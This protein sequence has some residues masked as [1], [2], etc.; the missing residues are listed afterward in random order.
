MYDIIN[1][2]LPLPSQWCQPTA[3]ALPVHLITSESVLHT[4]VKSQTGDKCGPCKWSL[5]ESFVGEPE[6]KIFVIKT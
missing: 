2:S 1:I 3:T 6:N 4:G 5:M